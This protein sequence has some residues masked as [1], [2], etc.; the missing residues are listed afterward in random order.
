[1]P[2]ALSTNPVAE[3][4]LANSTLRQQ[5]SGTWTTYNAGVLGTCIF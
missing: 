3:F 1:M 4:G 2:T 5:V